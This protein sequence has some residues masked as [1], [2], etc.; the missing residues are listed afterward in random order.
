MTDFVHERHDGHQGPLGE[1]RRIVFARI[2]PVWTDCIV[3]NGLVNVS[4]MPARRNPLLARWVSSLILGHSLC[5]RMSRRH[6]GEQN[7][8][9]SV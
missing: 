4:T 5:M 9:I 2:S 8:R 3:R 1:S 7:T 6:S